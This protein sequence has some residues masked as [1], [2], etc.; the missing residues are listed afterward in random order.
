L[1]ARTTPRDW[2]VSVESPEGLTD[3]VDD[4][5]RLAESLDSFAET[6]GAAASLNAASRMLA[7]TFTVQADSEDAAGEAG[8]RAFLVALHSAGL[9]VA[10]G[11]VFYVDINPASD[12][13]AQ[14]SRAEGDRYV[15]RLSV[16]R[17]KTPA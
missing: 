2:L 4:L 17:E 6:R 7:A 13:E 14:D 9:T 8:F 12:G 1:S 5:E 10:T 3:S 16:E 15:A 11:S